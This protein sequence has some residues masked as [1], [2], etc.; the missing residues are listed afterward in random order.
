M[1]FNA[2]PTAEEVYR[3]FISLFIVFIYVFLVFLE[4][5]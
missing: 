4:H 3:I 1:V 2:W 5:T